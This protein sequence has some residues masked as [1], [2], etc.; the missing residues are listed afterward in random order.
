[1]VRDLIRK[2]LFFKFANHYVAEHSRDSIS[3]VTPAILDAFRKFL[4]DEKFDYQEDTETKIQDLRQIAE[5]SHYSKDV[6]ADLDRVSLA[7]D[8]EK[9]RGFERYED[10]IT[11]ELDIELMARL[12]GE[13]GRIAASLIDDPQLRVAV[14][15]LSDSI[16][17]TKKLGG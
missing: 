2:A 12:K 10:H 16:G 4:V 9:E 15:M 5:R 1:M 8:H 11:D 6:L 3:G 14:G 17:Y 13:H 7:F